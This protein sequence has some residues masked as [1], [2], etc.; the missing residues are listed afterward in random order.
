ML[1]VTVDSIRVPSPQDPNALRICKSDRSLALGQRP[2]EDLCRL[3]GIEDLR[4]CRILA[5][6]IA[7]LLSPLVA[8]VEGLDDAIHRRGNFV[9]HRMEIV[10]N[11]AAEWGALHQKRAR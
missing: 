6:S 7:D 9:A 2:L 1:T 5:S 3:D 8:S 10:V 4:G 11:Q